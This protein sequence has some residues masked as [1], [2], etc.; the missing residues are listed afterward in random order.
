M[1]DDDAHSA[2]DS[3]RMPIRFASIK[4]EYSD[5]Y[6]DAK[7]EYRHVILPHE[8]RHDRAMVRQLHQLE[9]LLSEDEWREIGL[10]MSDGWQHYGFFGNEPHVM[11]FRRAL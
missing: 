7:H 4:I 8:T 11:L 3:I 2:P 5:S 9:R 1:S 6:R 10:Q